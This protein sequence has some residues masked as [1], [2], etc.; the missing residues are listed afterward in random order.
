MSGEHTPSLSDEEE[1]DLDCTNSQPQ[2]PELQDTLSK[3]TNYLHGWQERWV[4]LS[5]GTLSYYKS[6]YDTAFGCRGSMSVAKAT[7]Q[8]SSYVR[9]CMRVFLRTESADI[10]GCCSKIKRDRNSKQDTQILDSGDKTYIHY[11]GTV[12]CLVFWKY[13][14]TYVDVWECFCFRQK[15]TPWFNT[16]TYIVL[17]C[18]QRPFDLPR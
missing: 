1:D 18:E 14:V 15:K 4:V 3:W 11:L 5:G 10:I 16:H 7:I 9:T 13:I 2:L 17:P 8:V 6:E 12:K